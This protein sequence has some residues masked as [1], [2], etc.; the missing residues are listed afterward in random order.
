MTLLEAFRDLGPIVDA[1]TRLSCTRERACE[2]VLNKLR[3]LA[4]GIPASCRE[5]V[6]AEVC[7]RLIQSGPRGERVDGPQS[8]EQ[9]ERYLRKSISNQRVSYHRCT[10]RETAGLPADVAV[11]ATFETQPDQMR[12]REALCWAR[13]HFFERIVPALAEDLQQRGGEPTDFIDAMKELREMADG[14]VPFGELV[15]REGADTDGTARNRL[16]QRHCRAR[17]RVLDWA[18]TQLPLMVVDEFR[19]WALGFVICELQPRQD[20]RSRQLEDLLRGER[21]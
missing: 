15:T 18:R 4:V 5:D 8:E 10:A 9:V 21:T 14:T 1:D 19:R 12:A 13:R 11:T 17:R 16:Y 6:I 2:V 3:Q 20:R 7:V